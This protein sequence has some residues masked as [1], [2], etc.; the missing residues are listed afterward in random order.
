MQQGLRLPVAF[1]AFS[2]TVDKTGKS[3]PPGPPDSSRSTTGQLVRV[4]KPWLRSQPE[5]VASWASFLG[6]I[7][8]G[9]AIVGKLSYGNGTEKGRIMKPKRRKL[10]VDRPVQFGLVAMLV[11]H[12]IALLAAVAVLLPLFRA[13]VLI[14]V[15]TPF[16]ERAAQAG[17][18]AVMLCAVLLLLLPYFIYDTFR[19]TNRFAGPIYRLHRTIRETAQG[20]PFRPIKFRKGDHWHDVAED[21]NEMV[22]RLQESPVSQ[23]EADQDAAEQQEPVQV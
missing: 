17:I 12:W 10:L 14:D 16:A 13:V 19:T 21:F 3:R 7:F 8:K 18:D 6:Y 23:H 20:E 15:T 5:K 11:F 2:L 22:E 9:H 1:I 4:T